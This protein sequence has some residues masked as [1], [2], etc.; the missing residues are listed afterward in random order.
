MELTVW[1][2]HGMLVSDIG[3]LESQGT[4]ILGLSGTKRSPTL[5]S[6]VSHSPILLGT[7]DAEILL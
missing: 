2:D 6:I 3:K 5:Y 7:P 1:F 4:A